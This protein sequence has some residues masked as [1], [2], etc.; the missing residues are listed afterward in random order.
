[1]ALPMK[2]SQPGGHASPAF[3]AAVRR[4]LGFDGVSWGEICRPVAGGACPAGVAEN[5]G[6]ENGPQV[7]YHGT[8]SHMREIE[9]LAPVVEAVQA[10]SHHVHFA[11]FGTRD[12]QQLYG[13]MPRV[14]SVHP[15][16]WLNYLSFTSI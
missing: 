6:G 11:L 12:V 8:A 9:W 4:V 16:R 10:R 14:A 7:C 3:A 13:Q 5:A 1:M 15:M 2:D